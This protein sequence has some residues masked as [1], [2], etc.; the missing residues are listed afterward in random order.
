MSPYFR[1]KDKCQ[2][3]A[4]YSEPETEEHIKGKQA[5]YEWIKKQKGVTGVILEGWL[6]DT[7]Q[8]PDIMFKYND[9]QYVIE[10][11]C[12]PIATEYI[13]RHELYQAA[14]IVDIWILGTKNYI[15]KPGY[16]TNFRRKKI[17]NYADF[18]YDTCQE[19]ILSGNKKVDFGMDLSTLGDTYEINEREEQIQ[20]LSE[21]GVKF[22]KFYFIDGVWIKNADFDIGCRIINLK[23][24]LSEKLSEMLL[25]YIQKVN[26]FNTEVTIF[27]DNLFAKFFELYSVNLNKMSCRFGFKC[28]GRYFQ[29]KSISNSYFDVGLFSVKYKNNSP[30]YELIFPLNLKDDMS[31]TLAFLAKE[32]RFFIEI[33]EREIEFER[34][35]TEH[36]EN[37]KNKLRHH[38][39]T[40]Y[41]LFL[42]DNIKLDNVRFL[43]L[44]NYYDDI[45]KLGDLVLEKLEF[46]D[47]IGA[48]KYVLMIPRKKIRESVSN[49][50]SSYLVRNYKECVEG[51]F[52]ELGMAFRNYDDLKDDLNID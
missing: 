30:I 19:V 8:R 45:Y 32:L 35:K 21:L 47:K 49:L 12:T 31:K 40:L 51:D 17:E 44:K 43:L 2:C 16:H 26:K 22:G 37:V 5:L 7:K 3:E 6:P 9:R 24:E 48:N 23:S 36:F 20:N 39:K 28:Y 13:E 10:Y 29:I 27:I 41:L 14:G 11:Q 25:N 15:N 33:R 34:K 38:K 46:L 4:L 42:E 18:Y 52:H 50:H 1:H